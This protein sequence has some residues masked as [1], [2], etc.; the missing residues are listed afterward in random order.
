[1]S[2]P[3]SRIHARFNK[4]DYAPLMCCLHGGN[5]CYTAFEMLDDFGFREIVIIHWSGK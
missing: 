5:W 2:F 4:K 1:M 3:F